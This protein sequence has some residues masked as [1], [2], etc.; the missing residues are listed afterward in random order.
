VRPLTMTREKRLAATTWAMGG[1]LALVAAYVYLVE[2]RGGERQQRAATAAAHLLP[3]GTDA[4]TELVLEKPEARIVCRREGRRWRIL[5]PVRADAD[6]TTI[7]RVLSDVAE[8]RIDRTVARQPTHL[9]EYGLDRPV[10]IGV[11]AGGQ[12]TLIRIGK[13]NLTGDRVFVQK[14]TSG[15]PD[16]ARAPV[17]L[18]D[19]QVRNVAEKSLYD[20]REKTVLNFAPEEVRTI[21]FTNGHGRIVLEGQPA[22]EQAARTD[23]MI[24]RPFRARADR[25]AIE[26][27][28]NLYSYL[29]AE[30][31]A[32]EKP[33]RLESYGLAPPAAS[34]R[35]GLKGRPSQAILLGRS[36]V[37]GALTRWFARLPGNSPV[38]T[39]NDNLPRDAQQ[40]PEGWRDRHATDF[41]RA[42]VAEVRLIR[43]EQTIVCA[44]VE[45]AGGTRWQMATFSG[46]VA[47]GMNLGA[48]AKMPTAPRADSDRVD[49][50]LAHLGTIDAKRFVEGARAADRRFGLARP[51]LKVVAFDGS[52][53]VVASVTF[54]SAVGE[55]RYATG[56]HLGGVFLVAAADARRFVVRPDELTAR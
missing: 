37:D 18:V 12:R 50:L 16:D 15:V 30:R 55:Q 24:T 56:P 17:L 54:G 13:D 19:R 48:A 49:Q 51:T 23:W 38:F 14:Q 5:S 35:F 25:G 45:D 10:V 44:R 3:F 52:A 39:I 2:V 20:L 4:V 40:Q 21:V 47:E 36:T 11:G 29:R 9:S 1:F 26:R 32:S 34:V 6:D 53:K 7:A 31:F 41:A 46:P 8:A 22:G 27:S 43:P 33:E 28:L 42:D